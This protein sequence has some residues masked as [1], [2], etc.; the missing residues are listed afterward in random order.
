MNQG[1]FP[2]LLRVSLL[3]F[4][5][6]FSFSACMQPIVQTS[7]KFQSKF[8]KNSKIVTIP[9][10][11]EDAYASLVK[12]AEKCYE[13]QKVSNKTMQFTAGKLIQTLHE[14]TYDVNTD[15]KDE[16]RT[17]MINF[18]YL[19]D[20]RPR[21]KSFVGIA[22]LSSEGKGTKLVHYQKY[23]EISAAIVAWS[24]GENHACPTLARRKR[25]SS[26]QHP[27]AERSNARAT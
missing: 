3:M 2:E 24:M 26:L 13:N 20:E 16:K 4:F 18:E 21:Y 6:A 10:K 14:W 19:I 1:L 22:E 25:Y 5:T 27:L 15:A 8:A 17:V 12:N 7:E 23:D 11:I 9:R